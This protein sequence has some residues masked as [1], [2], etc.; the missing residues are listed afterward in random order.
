MKE[1]QRA[2]PN[3]LKGILVF[4]LHI[5]RVKYLIL[6]RERSPQM[7]YHHGRE[8]LRSRFVWS[9]FDRHRPVYGKLKPFAATLL[10][11]PTSFAFSRTGDFL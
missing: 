4:F 5:S 7:N 10:F 2:L 3:N 1:C 6:R 11:C 9:H 8:I